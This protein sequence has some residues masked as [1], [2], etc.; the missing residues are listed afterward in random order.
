[1]NEVSW[2]FIY[3]Q[4]NDRPQDAAQAAVFGIV[5][6]N[7]FVCYLEVNQMQRICFAVKRRAQVAFRRS[8]SRKLDLIENCSILYIIST[9][10]CSLNTN[11]SN[12][13][14]NENSVNFGKTV[15][16]ICRKMLMSWQT[17]HS[18]S[19]A[20]LIE[21]NVTKMVAILT[22]FW[23]SAQVSFDLKGCL[24]LRFLFNKWFTEEK[25]GWVQ[26]Q[27]AHKIHWYFLTTED[28]RIKSFKLP[29]L[30]KKTFKTISLIIDDVLEASALCI[31][32]AS[33]L[34]C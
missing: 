3:G 9:L 29:S 23:F 30:K 15:E 25:M 11:F 34:I 7:E 33:H 5:L 13:F 22:L 12:I 10:S 20:G 6:L 24:N 4:E 26:A 19:N 1:M 2:H 8:S 32:V 18:P 28:V 31:R 16:Q 17:C 27:I 14:W 21:R